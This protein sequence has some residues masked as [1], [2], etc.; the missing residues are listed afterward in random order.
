MSSDQVEVERML[1]L[2]CWYS[3]NSNTARELTLR[4]TSNFIARNQ[5]RC[6]PITIERA[7]HLCEPLRESK[8]A[9]LNQLC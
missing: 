1:S 2:C 4:L 3:F 6:W 7:D 8:L 9:Q 5:F